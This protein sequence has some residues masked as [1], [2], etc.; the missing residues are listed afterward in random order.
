M[1]SYIWEV[2]PKKQSFS[3]KVHV[4]KAF[5]VFEKEVKNIYGPPKDKGENGHVYRGDIFTATG[6]TARVII[7]FY[8]STLLVRIHIAG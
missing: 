1:P 3:I 2:F 6:I 4:E 5:D 8:T 7:T